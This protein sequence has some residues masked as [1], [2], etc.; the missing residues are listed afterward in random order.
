MKDMKERMVG[1]VC[2]QCAQAGKYTPA[3]GKDSH[4]Y[5]ACEQHQIATP[6][7]K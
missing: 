6:K 2:M 7:P 4:H 5:P 1:H 3:V